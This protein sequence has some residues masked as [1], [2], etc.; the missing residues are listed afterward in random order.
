[1]CLNPGRITREY[2]RTFGAVARA[3]DG[4]DV[5]DGVDLVDG[6]DENPARG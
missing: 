3:V 4:V 6:V 5:M 1:M 2:F